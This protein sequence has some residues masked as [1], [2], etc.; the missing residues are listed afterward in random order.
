MNSVNIEKIIKRDIS[1]LGCDIWGVELSGRMSNQTLRIFIDKN[2]GVSIEDCERVSSHISKVLDADGELSKDYMLEVSS[3]GIDRKFFRIDQFLNY[4]G[5][6]IKIKHLTEEN[7]YQTIIGELVEVKGSL[8]KLKQH[9][10][11]IEIAFSSI[12]KA[13]LHTTGV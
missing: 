6:N 11:D 8:L 2:E 7:K 3:P 1:S 9:N 13:S 4:T 12:K 10:E 5:H